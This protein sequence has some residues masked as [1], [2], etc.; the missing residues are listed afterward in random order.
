MFSM[1]ENVSGAIM[2]V[3]EHGREFPS[4]AQAE[5]YFRNG[6]RMKAETEPKALGLSD[7]ENPSEQ[8]SEVASNEWRQ[9]KR[10]QQWKYL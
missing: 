10:V 3:R 9:T 7:L 2:F 6:E 4:P 1:W 8:P 5:S